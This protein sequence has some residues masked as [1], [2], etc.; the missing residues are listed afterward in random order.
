MRIL[1][2]RVRSLLDSRGSRTVEVEIGV[3]VAGRVS[4]RVRAIAPSGASTG[5]HEVQAFNKEFPAG[6]E[7]FRKRVAKALKGRDPRDQ[8]SVDATLREI[9]GTPRYERLGGNV[10]CA[11]SIATCKAAAAAEGLSTHK[12][13]AKQTRSKAG[14][15]APMGNVIGGGRHAIGGTDIQEFMAVS[16]TRRPSI[17]VFANAAVHNLVGKAL[18]EKLPGASIGKGDEGAWNAPISNTDAL[19]ILVAACDKVKTDSG[20]EVRPALDVAATEFFRDGGYE[21]KEG[22]KSPAEQVEFME[23]L[24]DDYGL[25]SVEDPFQEEDFVGF[26]NLVK[27]VGDRAL[28]IGD[29]LFCTNSERLERGTK[30]ESAN[31]ILIKV[32]QI[33]TLTDTYRAID[34]ARKAGYKHVVSHRSGDTTDE[35]IAHL[36]CGT[37]AW[38]IK[39]GAIGGER[40]AKLN[41]LIR[42]EEG[43]PTI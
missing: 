2:S 7:L 14:F 15:P 22:R 20:V 31:A 16:M 12:W 1:E 34:V 29:D 39:T 28:V 11:A 24:I 13:I 40:I 43:R 41:E 35:F 19:E 4:K 38:G 25:V 17:D 9:D 27:K 42:M 10:A 30:L 6:L 21:Y 33:G 32:N 37:G 36:A 18:K 8:A 3:G 23:S 5:S 26:H